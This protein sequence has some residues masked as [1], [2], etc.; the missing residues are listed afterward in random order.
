MVYPKH[1]DESSWKKTHLTSSSTEAEGK[2]R[3]GKQ[4]RERHIKGANAEKDEGKANQ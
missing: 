4:R 1:T 3:K 2:E